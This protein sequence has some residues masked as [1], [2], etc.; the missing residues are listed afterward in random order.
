MDF[1]YLPSILLALVWLVV[2]LTSARPIWGNLVRGETTHV[3][4]FLG[5]LFGSAAILTFPRG[6]LGERA[7]WLWIPLVLDLSVVLTVI[8]ALASVVRK[9]RS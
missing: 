6:T 7:V 1:S 2:T 8:L 3:T 4:L 5:F 9:I